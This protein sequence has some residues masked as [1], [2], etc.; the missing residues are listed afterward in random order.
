MTDT[1]DFIKKKQFE[2][3]KSKTIKERFEIWEGMINFGRRLAIVRIK[4]RL[5]ND[6][7]EMELRYELIKEYYGS[8]LGPERLA[9]LRYQ[10]MQSILRNM[11]PKHLLLLILCLVY[12]TSQAQVC[13]NSDFIQKH[14]VGKAQ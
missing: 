10:L 6:I 9:E 14:N 8:E 11:N 2:I 12:G 4:K 3:N 5:G 7:S 13:T 1:P